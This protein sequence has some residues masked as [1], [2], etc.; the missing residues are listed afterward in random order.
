MA[1]STNSTG[2]SVTATRWS[3]G[4]RARSR[5]ASA[6]LWKTPL[7]RLLKTAQGLVR[8]LL[9]QQDIAQV[10]QRFGVVRTQT[11]GLTKGGYGLGQPVALGQQDAEIVVGVRG[12]G[13]EEKT[14]M[15]TGNGVFN[16][17]LPCQGNGQ[18][19]ARFP[20]LRTQLQQ[21]AIAAHRLI[22]AA[23]VAQQIGQVLVSAV[24][25]RQKADGLLVGNRS[26]G[27]LA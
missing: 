4:R 23:P 3:N 15:Q 25:G 8:L 12:V 1:R 6:T 13:M 9:P 20:M 27:D 17:L 11:Q 16:Q 24:V 10:V 7:Q 5:S 2:L 19:E 18:L 21:A 26:Q 14:L 22:E